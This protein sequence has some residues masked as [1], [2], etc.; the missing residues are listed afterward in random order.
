MSEEAD[1]GRVIVIDI[2]PTNRCNA[3][4][5][6]CPRDKTPHE[7]LMSPATFEQ[8][9]ARVEEFS[10]F[11]RDELDLGIQVSL[12]GLGEPLLN[13]A[14]PSYIEKVRGAGYTCVMSSNAS[15]LNERRGRRVLDAG[16]QRVL[17]NV[18]DVGEDYEDVYKL[19]FG[20]TRDN[21]LRFN[22]MAG[23]DCDVVIILVDYKDDQDHVDAMMDYWR[24]HGINKFRSYGI[25][26]RGGSLDVDYMQYETY[27]ELAQ[28]KQIF[29][30]MD[31][32]VPMCAAPFI[33]MFV[34]YDG[35]YYLCC[36][37][38]EKRAPLG[39]VYDE[40]FLTVV[41]EKLRNVVERTPV[42]HTC[43]C[44]PLNQLTEQLR[45]ENMGQSTAGETATM[46]RMLDDNRGPVGELVEKMQLAAASQVAAPT[47][48]K[49][50]PVTSE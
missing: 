17:I 12:C 20:P 45:A 8:A 44:D 2:E 23:D 24:S 7:G 39:T 11:A 43:N 13:P 42:C 29:A 21:I 47:L 34:G 36:S 30:E 15:I 25:M 38:W 37:D 27:P 3:K 19:D 41:N 10:P 26:N 32:S 9:F 33:Y 28:A 35:Q 31:G 6:F 5:H 1:D 16:L 18:G 22:E 50:I 48:R 4:C 46:I 14:T 49:L 40:T